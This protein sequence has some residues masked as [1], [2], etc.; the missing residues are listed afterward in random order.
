MK[1]ILLV[2]LLLIPFNIYAKEV[3]TLDK[4]I[5]GDTASFNINGEIKKVRFLAI[6]APEYTSK[7]KFYGKES[8]EYV[9]DKLTKS[10]KIE[11]E[12]DSKSDKVDKYDRVL[13]WIYVDDKLLQSELVEFGYVNVA[14]IYDKYMYVDDLCKLQDK[15][16]EN[17]KGIWQDESRKIGYCSTHKNNNY[18]IDNIYVYVVNYSLYIVVLLLF[19]CLFII[20]VTR[21][22]G[23]RHA[24][25]KKNKRS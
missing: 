1:K 16:L 4:C 8:S 15:A 17:K 19:I 18:Y 20:I 13:A 24:K 2:L 9:C 23:E 10:S 25:H 5:D 6:N 12:Y 14:Y 11:I 3:V 7:I 22:K 21:K